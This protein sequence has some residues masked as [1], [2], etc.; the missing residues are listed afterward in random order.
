MTAKA[1]V[2]II[3]MVYMV[4]MAVAIRYRS[5][6]IAGLLAF[7]GLMLGLGNI[8]GLLEQIRDSTSEAGKVQTHPF[9]PIH[10]GANECECGYTKDAAIHG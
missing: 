4:L 7:F 1:S 6:E 5:Y 3:A 8:C 2:M 9:D 10:S